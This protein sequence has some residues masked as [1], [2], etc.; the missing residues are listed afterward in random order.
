MR[1][2][3]WMRRGW[4][5]LTKSAALAATGGIALQLG[6]CFDSAVGFA[7]N[8]NPCATILNCDPGDYEFL[9]SGYSGPGADPD[10]DL[11]CTFPPFCDEPIVPRGGLAPLP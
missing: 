9:T 2:G 10:V 11:A 4:L 6:G 5:R 7:R 8:F 3:G 1:R